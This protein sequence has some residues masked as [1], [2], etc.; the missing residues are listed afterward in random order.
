M[1]SCLSDVLTYPK[2]AATTQ[3]KRRGRPGLTTKAT[4]LTD[5]D[6]LQ[7]LKDQEEQKKTKR[8]QRRKKQEKLSERERK[9]SLTGQKRKG[10]K[11]GTRRGKTEKPTLLPTQIAMRADV[12]RKGVHARA[13]NVG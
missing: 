1:S 8:K 6:F 10:R 2:A 3:K 13:L 9:M 4:C 11:P 12:V 7:G 5:D